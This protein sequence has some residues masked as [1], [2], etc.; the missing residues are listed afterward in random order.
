MGG[1]TGTAQVND[2]DIENNSWFIA[3]APYE[4]P[5]IAI[6]VFIPNGYAGAES[7]ITVKAIVEY[8]LDL[9][10]NVKED[11]MPFPDTIVS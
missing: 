8:Y 4:K 7:S 10:Y 6:V 1:K 2:I 5:E 11:P 3:F 9:K